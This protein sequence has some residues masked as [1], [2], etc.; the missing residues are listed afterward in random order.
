MRKYTKLLLIGL[1]LY[2][3]SCAQFG[4]YLENR[5][6]DLADPFMVR[7]GYGLGAHV[8]FQA[9][10]VGPSVVLGISQ[11]RKCGFI[12]REYVYSSEAFL[13]IALI[14]A[15]GYDEFGTMGGKDY[16]YNFG[17]RGFIDMTAEV[18]F[19]S[20]GCYALLLGPQ[21]E[22]KV[23]FQRDF[24]KNQLKHLFWIEADVC[25]F[26]DLNVGFNP[27]EFADFLL[28]FFTIDISDDDKHFSQ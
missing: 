24:N 16:F 23:I 4:T 21:V 28:G 17:T 11:I 12:G 27:Y 8:S 15:R 7:V 19:I 25:V 5:A 18:L 13:G 20:E 9:T 14:G 1:F 3:C 22:D 6:F 2:A 10:R 26:G